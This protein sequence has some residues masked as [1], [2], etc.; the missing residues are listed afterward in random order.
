MFVLGKMLLSPE[1][2]LVVLRSTS[3]KRTKRNREKCERKKLK[4]GKFKGKFKLK[5]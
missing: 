5:R 1:Y 4:R 2:W 3:M